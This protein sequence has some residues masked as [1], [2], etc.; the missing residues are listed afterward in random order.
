MASRKQKYAYLSSIGLAM[1]T[2]LFGVIACTENGLSTKKTLSVHEAEK[3]L[4]EK[5]SFQPVL[6]DFDVQELIHKSA[7]HKLQDSLTPLQNKGLITYQPF[8][9]QQNSDY[10]YVLINI[11]EKGKKY[12]AGIKKVYEKGIFI[13]VKSCEK[14]LIKVT[15]IQPRSN[16]EDKWAIVNYEWAYDNQ[17]PF[18][19]LSPKCQEKG[20]VHTGNYTFTFYDKGWRIE[21]PVVDF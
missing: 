21:D 19:Y 14:K 20:A 12:A 1:L 13:E 6:A 2:S 7:L 11:T 4:A 8:E 15:E 5:L 3:L 16:S 9:S 17:T 10:F 18:A